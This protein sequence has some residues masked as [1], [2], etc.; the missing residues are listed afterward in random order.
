MI[1]CPVTP[2]YEAEAAALVAALAAY[3][4]PV[5]VVPYESAGAWEANTL[6]RSVV[7]WRAHWRDVE[8]QRERDIGPHWIVDADLEVVRD[9]RDLFDGKLLFRGM[10]AVAVS[11]RHDKPTLSKD[12]TFSAGIVGWWNGGRFAVSRWAHLCARYQEDKRK[13]GWMYSAPEQA[14]LYDALTDK[15]GSIPIEIQDIP[16]QFQVLPQDGPEAWAN[17]VIRHPPA[18]R[19][20]KKQIGRIE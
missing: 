18:S 19:T 9:P 6:L 15:S 14:M 8:A 11:R 5:T 1:Y 7:A 12:F 16:P 13:Y 4:I 20:K 2:E 17:A 10:G 3:S